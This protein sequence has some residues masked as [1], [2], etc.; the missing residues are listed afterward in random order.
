M[1]AETGKALEINTAGLRQPIGKTSPELETVKRFRALGGKYVTYGSDAHYAEH[2]GAGL[3][4]AYDMM[5]EAGFTHFTFFQQR[6]PLQ[7]PIE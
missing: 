1:T 7:M 2:I 3:D 4:T 6:T 5:R